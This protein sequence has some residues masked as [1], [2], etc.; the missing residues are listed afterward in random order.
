MNNLFSPSPPGVG[1]ATGNGE[2]PRMKGDQYEHV[3]HNRTIF[4][5]RRGAHEN[6]AWGETTMRCASEPQNRPDKLW[7]RRCIDKLNTYNF[8]NQAPEGAKQTVRSGSWRHGCLRVHDTPFPSKT[9]GQACL[10]RN[11][12]W[13]SNW[14]HLELN[15]V[16]AY[17][18]DLE[19]LLIRIP[20]LVEPV[21]AQVIDCS[22]LVSSLQ[23]VSM[24]PDT[25]WC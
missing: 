16:W 13:E 9:T 1:A 19:R 6:G 4:L 17:R 5:N 7:V 23:A 10:G 2:L 15:G 21:I 12:S 18:E 3:R 11:Q 8:G 24:R 22:T 14:V 25:C 20:P